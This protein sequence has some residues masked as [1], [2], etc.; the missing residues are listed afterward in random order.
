MFRTELRSAQRNK[1]ALL[2]QCEKIVERVNVEHSERYSLSLCYLCA[3]KL[4][5]LPHQS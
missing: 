1:V 5:Y 4:N 2:S 3:K